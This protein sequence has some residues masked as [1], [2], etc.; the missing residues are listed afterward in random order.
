ML[1]I[2]RWIAVSLIP[3]EFVIGLVLAP[4][5][6]SRLSPLHGWTDGSPG[7]W[8]LLGLALVA[9]G[10]MGVVWGV[11]L[12][13]AKMERSVQVELTPKYLLKEGP[14]G[15]SRNPIFISVATMWLGW[16][17]V[18]GSVATGL[19]LLTVCVFFALV[20]VPFEER[21]LERRFGDRYLRY[22]NAV[23]RWLGRMRV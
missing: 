10:T 18:Y 3:V 7:P 11:S 19:V 16:T 17:I 4:Y 20:A 1:R 21:G 23:P 22:K 14:Y 15:F 8:N 6:I 13:V 5:W 9:A 2:P 12:H